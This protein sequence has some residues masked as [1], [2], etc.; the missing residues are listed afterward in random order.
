M[1]KQEMLCVYLCGLISRPPPPTFL[2]I[3]S[4]T[5]ELE[6]EGLEKL[7]E[8]KAVKEKKAELEKKL[9]GLRKKFEK[10]WRINLI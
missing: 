3:H 7:M 6:A 5:D 9:E 1:Y 4:V 2:P 10:V 8:N